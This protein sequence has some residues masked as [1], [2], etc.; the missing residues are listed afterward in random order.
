MPTE[1]KRYVFTSDEF[2]HKESEP[3]VP[4]LGFEAA[5]DDLDVL[6]NGMLHIEFIPGTP[7]SEVAKITNFLNENAKCI[8]YTD[9][10][11]K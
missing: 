3:G 8:T 4:W 7:Y 10:L 6:K 1:F 9:L 5:E 11:E 2:S